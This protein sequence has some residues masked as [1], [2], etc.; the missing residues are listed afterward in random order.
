[1]SKLALKTEEIRVL[2]TDELSIVDGGAH[3]TSSAHPPKQT[4]SSA[5]KPTATAV[6]SAYKPTGFARPTSTAVS[7]ARPPGFA[8]PTATAVSSA[9]RPW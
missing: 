3:K 4:V 2:T 9:Y 8:Q 7:S 5:Y 1:M 6:S